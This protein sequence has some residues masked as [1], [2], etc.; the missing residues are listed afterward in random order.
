M[1][2]VEK[3]G[4]SKERRKARGERRRGE[5]ELREENGGI[6]KGTRGN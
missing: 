1:G 6:R 4:E 2:K 3:K 5:R